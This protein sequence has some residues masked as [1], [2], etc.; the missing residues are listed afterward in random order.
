MPSLES[1]TRHIM[2]NR[3]RHR[4]K[5]FVYD[6]LV[7]D[8]TNQIIF[9]GKTADLSQSGARMIG[10]PVSTGAREG[11][12]AQV[13]F[14]ILPRDITQEVHRMTIAA[15]IVR[16]SETEDSYSLGVRFDRELGE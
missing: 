5:H 2:N 11:Q 8:E 14:L 9:R 6:T 10:L 12:A 15:R 1:L 13:E 3:R 7:R 16:V 4:R